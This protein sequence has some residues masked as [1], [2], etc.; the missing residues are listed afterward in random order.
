MVVICLLNTKGGIGKTTLSA[1]LGGLL[2]DLN[3][4]VLLIDTDPQGSLSKYYK[5]KHQASK[6]LVE[7]LLEDEL[8]TD[9]FSSTVFHNLDIVL[10]N[11]STAHT[12]TELSSRPDRPIL[13]REK[14]NHPLI[15]EQYD[16]VIIDTQGAVGSLQ[17][18]AAFASDLILSPI[19]PEML[20]AREFLTGTQAMLKRLSFGRK[21]GLDIPPTKALLYAMDRTKD[22]RDIGQWL[23]NTF[24]ESNAEVQLLNTIIPSAKAYKEAST[25]AVPVHIHEIAHSG[26]S[27]SANKVMH[28]LVYE[29]FPQLSEAKVKARNF[30][31][32]DEDI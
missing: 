21:I 15:S 1:N 19:V 27:E 2:A 26:K 10:S 12:Q 14:I 8:T 5:L 32:D 7:L 17:E 20:S 24:A 29:L 30:Q 9:V 28:D 6:G 4:R 23:V 3:F 31:F 13:L 22:A 18:T 11:D 25:K 16:V